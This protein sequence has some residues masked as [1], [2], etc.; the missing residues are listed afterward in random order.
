MIQNAQI[1]P[2]SYG[3]VEDLAQVKRQILRLLL[4]SCPVVFH[5]LRPHGLQPARRHAGILCLK[6]GPRAM[7][8][9][10]PLLSDSL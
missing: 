2:T 10:G 1:S 5:S 8:E 6:R 3:L 9:T 4:F 7:P